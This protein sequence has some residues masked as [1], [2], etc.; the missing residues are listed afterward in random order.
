MKVQV[1][2]CTE[3]R[4]RIHAEEQEAYLKKQYAYLHD[5]INT[6]A[7][8]SAAVAMA[9]MVKRGRTKKYI[10]QFYDDMV[11]LYSISEIMGKPINLSDVVNQLE[12]DYDI[13]FSR[14]KVNFTETEK[15]F[16]KGV[17]QG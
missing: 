15:E 7:K 4:K 13:D 6:M 17:K 2:N 3:C 8:M 5:G 11:M 9:V 16:I 12:K 1:K 10:Q 14:L